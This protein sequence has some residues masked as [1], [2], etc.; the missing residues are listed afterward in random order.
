MF[1]HWAAKNGSSEAGTL[2]AVWLR[3]RRRQSGLGP[4]AWHHQR[5]QPLFGSMLVEYANHVLGCHGKDL[6]LRH[7]QLQ[8]AA[9]LVLLRRTTAI[10]A[11]C[12][13][14]DSE[15]PLRQAVFV[16]DVPTTKTS[17]NDAV[18]NAEKVE[19]IDPASPKPKPSPKEDLRAAA[20]DDQAITCAYAIDPRLKPV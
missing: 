7:K 13:T 2:V 11:S 12:W 1:S 19:K 5:R 15:L 9:A 17:K 20:P 14:H 16:G 6:T 4:S 3:P 8:K 10:F 18:S